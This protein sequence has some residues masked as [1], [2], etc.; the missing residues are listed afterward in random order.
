MDKKWVVPWSEK[1]VSGNKELDFYHK[2]LLDDVAHLYDMLA[3]SAKHKE[4]IANLTS[5]IEEELF[6]H[7]AIEVDHLKRF[8]LPECEQHEKDHFTYKEKFDF[9]NANLMPV[10]IRAVLTGEIALDYMNIHFFK[11]DSKDMPLINQ[12]LREVGE[13][14]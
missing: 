7:M 13:I 2:Q 10:V 12:K 14:D 11:F 1:F 3:D 5:K 6:T 4:D 9:Y 8:N